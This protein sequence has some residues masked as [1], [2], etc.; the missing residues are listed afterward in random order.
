MDVIF[1]YFVNLEEFVGCVGYYERV[2]NYEE[3]TEG[4]G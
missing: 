3:G 1:E 2:L 4:E